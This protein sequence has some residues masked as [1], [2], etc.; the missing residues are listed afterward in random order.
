[1]NQYETRFVCDYVDASVKPATDMLYKCVQDPSQGYDFYCQT[2]A[3]PIDRKNTSYT[4]NSAIHRGFVT[5]IQNLGQ[6][7]PSSGT[8]LAT[9][10]LSGGTEGFANYFVTD[11]G[12]GES[13][14]RN[15]KCPEG[16]TRCSKTGKCIQVCTNCSYRDGMKSKDF[17]EADPC[18]PQGVYD[19]VDQYG[20]TKCSCGEDNKYC[21]DRFLNQFTADGSLSLN[22]KMKNTIGLTDRVSKLFYFGQL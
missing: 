3:D 12:P 1:M 13:T 17:N 22:N 5:S 11:N 10:G 2:S 4:D 8:A 18:F 6:D 15:G 20:F 14:V 21:S 19:G 16:Y 9:P 7:T